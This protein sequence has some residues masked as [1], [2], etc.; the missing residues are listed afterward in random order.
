MSETNSERVTCPDCGKGYRWQDALAGRT[1]ACKQCGTQFTVPDAPGMGLA[2]EPTNDDGIYDLETPEIDQPRQLTVP[3]V[4]GKCPNCN[5]PVKEHAVLCLNCGF[6]M[7]QGT[8]IQTEVA[9]PVDEADIEPNKVDGPLSRR[10]QRDRDAAE[11]IH[12][13]HRWI[14]YKL[15]IILI[16]VGCLLTL[17]N[18][19]LLAPNAPNLSAGLSGTGE[20]FAV[21]TIATAYA[22]VVNSLLLFA[23]LFLLLWLFGSSFGALGSVLLKILAITLMAQEVD[24]MAVAVFDIVTGAGFLGIVFSWAIYL[25]MMVGLCMKLL[26]VD[27]AEFRVLIVF[28]IIGR[29]VADITLDVL[30][31]MMF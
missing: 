9:E 20:V 11:Q 22:M 2:L 28:I 12:A 30:I 21:Y 27:V 13:E 31:S 26:D 14:D 23:G 15:P 6:N 5:S 3:A 1:V 17:I 4:G 16:I 8:K 19:A 10:E 18:N 25:G 7:Q 29:V 24:F